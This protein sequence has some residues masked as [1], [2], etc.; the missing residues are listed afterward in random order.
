MKKESLLK[1]KN[2]IIHTIIGDALGSSIDGLSKKH[3]KSVFKDFTTFLDAEIALK[4]KVERWSKPGLYTSI[5]QLLL[6]FSLIH[7]NRKKLLKDSLSQFKNTVQQSPES[8]INPYGIFRN[9]GSVEQKFLLNLQGEDI[10]SDIPHIPCA[11]LLP[12]LIPISLNIESTQKHIINSISLITSFTFDSFTISAALFYSFLIKN[13]I[14][15]TPSEN[16]ISFSINIIQELS[17]TIDKI[18]PEIFQLKINPDY[19]S[20]KLQIF[21]QIL[22]SIE[23]KTNIT[24]AENNIIELLNKQLKTPVTRATVNH[25]FLI[26]PFSLAYI[27]LYRT[28]KT[29]LL[30]H[31]AKEGGASSILTAITGSLIGAL[32]NDAPDDSLSQK[33]V[34]KKRIQSILDSLGHNQNAEK[35]IE[36]FIKNELALTNKESEERNAKLKHQKKK[37]KKRKTKKQIEND[38]SRHVVES[39]TKL[40]KAKWKKEKKNIN[41]KEA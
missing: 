29:D 40:D 20:Q 6:I 9:P 34:N 22:E 38:L 17:D 23:N 8:S 7:N 1:L 25:P 18:S 30:I 33:L 10:N 24:D 14:K 36:G 35:D 28:E 19:V 21:T 39:W 5:S 12:I 16:I 27:N 31:V 32:N 26:L 15:K 13:I 41:D 11:R 2:I 3:I 37:Q 4:G